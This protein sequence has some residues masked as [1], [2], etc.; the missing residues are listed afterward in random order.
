MIQNEN[1]YMLT[2]QKWARFNEAILRLQR[3]PLDKMVE[4]EINSLARQRDELAWQME[5]YDRRVHGDRKGRW[6]SLYSG[7]RFWPE[8]PRPQDIDIRDIAHALSCI[9]RFNGHTRRPYSVAQH[10]VLG[11]RFIHPRLALAFLMHDAGECYLGDII[12]PIKRLLRE[13]YETAEDKVMAAVASRFGFDMSER[14]KAEVKIMDLIM[15]STEVRDLTT[16]GITCW[17]LQ[18]LPLDERITECWS[19][20]EAEQRFLA[21]FEELTGARTADFWQAV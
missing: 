17:P 13:F 11:S 2:K 3:N 7:T 18:E 10:C 9:N 4:L 15:L 5:E 1:Q 16:T 8:D 6:M 12:T 19:A 21:R 20:E 14:V